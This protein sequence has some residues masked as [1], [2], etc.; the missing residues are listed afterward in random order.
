VDQAG[1]VVIEAVG[2]GLHDRVI[3]T[4]S[5]ILASGAE[6]ELLNTDADAGT[7]AINLTGN[8]VAQDITGNAGANRLEGKG[9][10]D[11]LIGLSGADTFVF[12]T[13]LGGGNV[14]DILDFFAPLDRFLLS[15]NVFRA[16]TPGT[17]APAQFRANTTG[18][19]QDADD[20]IIYDTD[21]GGVF[22]D[23]DGLGGA[24]GV[25]F[26]LVGMGLGITRADFT[27]A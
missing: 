6:V 12:A 26:A 13:N 8:E 22:Y 5:F 4:A 1:D 23:A 18:L 15:D 19:A 11:T 20:R 2:Q 17:I 3:A 9:G 16:L 14:D 21:S 10:A 7:A 25:Q 27:V 24:A